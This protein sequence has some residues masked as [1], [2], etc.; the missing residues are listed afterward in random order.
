MEQNTLVELL[1]TVVIHWFA[2]FG[3]I[4]FPVAK[5]IIAWFSEA[6]AELTVPVFGIKKGPCGRVFLTLT[7]GSSQFLIVR[8]LFPELP[9]P[10]F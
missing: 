9:L 7:T 5:A 6:F 4:Y 8:R 3:C 1:R 10:V 2:S